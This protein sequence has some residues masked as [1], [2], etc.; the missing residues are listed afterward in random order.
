MPGCE[1]CWSDAHCGPHVS[2]ADEYSRLIAERSGERACTPEQQA[3]R[4]ARTCPECHRTA[5]HQ[6]CGICMACG[7]DP[8]A[9][10]REEANT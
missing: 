1:K 3:G 7:Y 9:C 6:F 5:L 2:V 8:G 4:D 10:G